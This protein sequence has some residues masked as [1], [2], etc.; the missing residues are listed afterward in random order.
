MRTSEKVTR[1]KSP[2]ALDEVSFVHLVFCT[3]CCAVC[4]RGV[5][6]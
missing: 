2:V 5:F 1:R 4:W 6:T 3:F